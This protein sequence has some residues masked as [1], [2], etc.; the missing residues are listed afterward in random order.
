MELEKKM[1]DE[2]FWE[3]YFRVYDVL[4]IV[5]PYQELMR[6]LEKELDLKSDD[7]VLDV[8][9]GTGNLIVRIKDKCKEIIGV[10]YSQE[11]I[12]IHKLKDPAA[13]VILHDITKRFPF[14]DNYFSKVV[15][16]NTIYTLTK[17]QQLRMLS[18][19]YRVMRP[20]GKFVISNVKKD[21]SPLEIYFNHISK[22]IKEQGFLKA[23]FLIIKMIIPT[24][25]M[26]YYNNKIRKS[27]LTNY[28]H[29]LTLKE[30][31]VLLRKAGFKNIS[32]ARYVFANQ[33]F[34]NS[35]YK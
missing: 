8:G 35:A 13:K 11:G 24:L 9:S 6:K 4:N 34:L 32:E 5:I 12:E 28:Y 33:A 14:P 30:Q 26:F 10:D 2:K 15:S 18:E 27:G 23:V 21:Y 31:K 17:R 16:N 3:K 29:F 25:K 1:L 7:I 22:N 19:I 20:G